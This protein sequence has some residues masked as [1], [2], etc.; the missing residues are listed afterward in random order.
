MYAVPS[1]CAL[2]NWRHTC[3][4]REPSLTG[5]ETHEQKPP[6]ESVWAEKTW[7]VTDKL[8]QAQS[9]ELW[10]PGGTA[11]LWWDFPPKALPG[12]HSENWRKIPFW[13]SLKH[14]RSFHSSY[15]GLP[16]DLNSL[17]NLRRVDFQHVQ[18]QACCYNGLMTSSS[19]HV[20]LEARSHTQMF[21]WTRFYFSWVNT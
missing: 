15:Q 21:L 14:T 4:H 20:G 16:C 13:T 7:T 1:V 2:T 3:R 5:A 19:E 10:P 8:L 12:S 11:T 18:L 9:W 6:R 17:M